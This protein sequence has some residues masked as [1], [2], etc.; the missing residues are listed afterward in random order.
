MR[1][2]VSNIEESRSRSIPRTAMLSR[3]QHRTRFGSDGTAEGVVLMRFM[4]DT[5]IALY[6]IR[7]DHP[8]VTKK[9]TELNEKCVISSITTAELQCGS[10]DP[11][12]ARPGGTS[13]LSFESTTENFR[14]AD[15]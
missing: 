6:L 15:A 11:A 1:Y 2:S 14:S 12:M 9:F 5:D 8:G 13:G 10:R 3:F 7:C 4:L